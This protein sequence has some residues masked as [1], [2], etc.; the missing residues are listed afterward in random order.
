MVFSFAV[1]QPIATAMNVTPTAA[2]ATSAKQP[3]MP[4][5]L[6]ALRAAQLPAARAAQLPAASAAPGYCPSS[7]GS[8]QFERIGSAALI[9]NGD[10]TM[11]LQVN[12]IIANP[13]GCVPGQE[14]PSYDPSPEHVNAWVDWNGDKTWDPS[15]HVM[16]KDLTGYL[17]INFAGTMTG[18]S[19]FVIPATITETTWLRVNL[20]YL[21]DPN[22]PCEASW[23]W[24][25]VSDQQVLLNVPTITAIKANTRLFASG[26][27]A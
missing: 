17:G 25:G 11:R 14:C 10:G 8:T 1:N 18:I 4:E 5:P 3:R 21:H 24:G 6:S 16:D 20:G 22:D 23:T 26:R 12:V 9:S 13:E 19:Q 7:G 15:E 2:P 27:W